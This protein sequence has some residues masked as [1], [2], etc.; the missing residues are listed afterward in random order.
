MKPICFTHHSLDQ[1]Y[2]RKATREEVETTI[3]ESKWEI[4]E[5]NRWT[6]AMSFDFNAEHY[7]RFYRYKEV[8][9]IF[10]EENERIA[11]ITVYTFFYNR[12]KDED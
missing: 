3:R 5:Q 4:A 1:M 2:E 12:R 10:V 8:V 11:V 7:G 6:G 9:P